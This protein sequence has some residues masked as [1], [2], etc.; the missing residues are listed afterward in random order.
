MNMW[1]ILLIAIIFS[2]LNYVF[3]HKFGNRDIKNIGDILL[4][5]SMISLI[6]AVIIFIISISGNNGFVM[7]SAGAIFYGTL[8]GLNLSVFL[9]FKM[10]SLTSGPISITSLIA[11]GS[12]IVATIFSVIYNNELVSVIKIIGMAVLLFSFFL[13][14]DR[15]NKNLVAT[16]K[17]KYYVTIFFFAGGMIGIINKLFQSSDAKTELDS[18][19]LVASIVSTVVLAAMAFILGGVKKTGI[20]KIYK[21]GVVYIIACGLVS[22]IYNRLN[23]YLAGVMDGALLFPLSNGTLLLLNNVTGILLFKEKLSKIQ[24]VGMIIGFL[25]IIMIGCF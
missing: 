1:I 8:Y 19:L 17:W 14:M 23:V 21:S 7:P 6:W 22:C 9:L 2:N 24:I 5:N 10:L 25:S 12:F 16:K 11:S 3:L 4:F 15:K 20:P 13:C 18:M